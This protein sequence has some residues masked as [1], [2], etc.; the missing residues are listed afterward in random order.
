MNVGAH[1]HTQ[2]CEHV[3]EHAR[4][5]AWTRVRACEC[6]R[7]SVRMCMPV[8]AR[9]RVC[10]YECACTSARACM[11][12][13]M[14]ARVRVCVPFDNSTLDKVVIRSNPAQK[15]TWDDAQ[16][17]GSQRMKQRPV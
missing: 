8:C 13:R 15:K 10:V 5:R 2:A 7:T 12:V 16:F 14:G 3:C 4:A 1:V 6:G 9:A 11:H 17:M